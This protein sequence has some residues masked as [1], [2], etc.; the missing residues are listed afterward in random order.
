MTKKKGTKGRVAKKKVTKVTRK[1]GGT[2]S[3]GP[4]KK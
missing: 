1:G 3:T 2:R 4:K